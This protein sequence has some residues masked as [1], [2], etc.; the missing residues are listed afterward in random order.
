MP[1]YDTDDTDDPRLMAAVQEYLSLKESGRPFERRKFMARHAEIADELSACLGGLA[2]V[3]SAAGNLRG[4]PP[5]PRRPATPDAID[6]E[7]AKPLGDFRLIREIGRGGMGT[8]YEAEQISLGR[9][10]ALKILPTAAA[11]DPRLLQRFRNEALA[12]AALHHTNVVPVH[13]VGNE[14]GVH[15]YAMQLIDGQSLA[16]VIRDLRAQRTITPGDAAAHPS[17]SL[18]SLRTDQRAEFYRAVALLGAQAADGLEYAHRAGVIHR[19]VK[20]GNLMLDHDG[21]LWIADFG[22]ALLQAQNSDS[23]LTLTGDVVGTLRYMSPE[24]AGARATLLDQRTDVYSLGATLFELLTLRPAVISTGDRWDVLAEVELADPPS[25]KLVDA[26][27]PVELD[28]ILGRAMAKDPAERYQSAAELA[29]DLRRFLNDEPIKAKPPTAVDR[30]RRWA[31]RNRR[32]VFAGSIVAAGLMIALLVTTVLVGQANLR[33]SRALAAERDRAAEAQASFERA[34]AAVDLLTRVAAEELA[35]NV[36]AEDERR[37]LLEAALDYY[38]GFVA[39][40]AGEEDMLELDQARDRVTALLAELRSVE[41]LQRVGEM[42]RILEQPSVRRELRVPPDHDAMRAVRD[43]LQLDRRGLRD[44]SPDERRVATEAAAAAGREAIRDMLDVDQY[45]RL[46]EI[47]WQVQGPRAFGDAVLA[48]MIELNH[49][50]REGVAR[51]LRDQHDAWERLQPRRG[52][53]GDEDGRREEEARITADAMSAVLA[54]M[55]QTQRAA[56]ESLRGEAFDRSELPPD[57]GSGFGP[58]FSSERGERRQLR[59]EDR[60]PGPPTPRARP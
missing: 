9:R 7:S 10:V 6:L 54:L 25:A 33:T 42:A 37:L 15:F 57:L 8:V 43:A 47:T 56:W 34:R 17:A 35:D 5:T 3:E 29:A 38:E 31:R 1:E 59:R 12:A 23:K 2:F 32:T 21:R 60:P 16:D 36:G 19:D 13:A 58:A 4:E 24:Q 41:S 48:D 18:L 46:R 30:A 20:P 55:T 40:R 44:L 53:P 52:P 22:L 11:M 28:T 26:T 45:D 39:E 27:V 14:R 50:Q 51:I 49:E